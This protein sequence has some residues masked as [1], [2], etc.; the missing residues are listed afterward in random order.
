VR[1]VRKACQYLKMAD[2]LDLVSLWSVKRGSIYK[3]LSHFEND[4]AAEIR[5]R[6]RYW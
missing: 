2:L 3:N 1:E 4:F 5:N 6:E